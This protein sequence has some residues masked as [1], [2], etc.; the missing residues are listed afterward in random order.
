MVVNSR[1]TVVRAGPFDESPSA[2]TAADGAEFTLLDA[3]GDWYQISDGTKPLGWLKT[4]AV[5]ALR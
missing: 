3:K 2:F 1:D 5:V 4:N